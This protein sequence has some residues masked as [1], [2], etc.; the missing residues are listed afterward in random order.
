M[1][2]NPVMKYPYS[3]RLALLCAITSV[4]SICS[5]SSAQD[6]FIV[7]VPSSPPSAPAPSSSSSSSGSSSS[8]DSSSSSSSYSPPSDSG[9]SSSTPSDHRFN[10][11][12]P[13]NRPSSG[14]SG[15]FH[16]GGGSIS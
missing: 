16:R 9:S 11:P 12:V 8:S 13:G 3:P 7:P 1:R 6:R 4:V 10:V 14:N 5:R 15:S 2:R